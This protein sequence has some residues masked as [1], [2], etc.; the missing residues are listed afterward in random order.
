MVT[1]LGV[2]DQHHHTSKVS[3]ATNGMLPCIHSGVCGMGMES[4]NSTRPTIHVKVAP[5]DADLILT[6]RVTYY[7][8]I[9]P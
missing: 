8:V 3:L 2:I 6:V 9:D 7:V 1:I 5:W 4:P